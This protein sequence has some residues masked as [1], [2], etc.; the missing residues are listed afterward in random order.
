MRQV[1][2]LDRSYAGL[3][4]L[5]RSLMSQ[6][7]KAHGLLSDRRR[8]QRQIRPLPSEGWTSEGCAAKLD[9]KTSLDSD[10]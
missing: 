6:M 8:Y 7:L 9:L 10:V 5:C 4:A 2:Q 3:C 1:L